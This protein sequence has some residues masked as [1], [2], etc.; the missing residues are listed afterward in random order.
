MY[1]N[2]GV[3][4]HVVFSNFHVP[5]SG[6]LECPGLYYR[7][8]VV[9]QCNAFTVYMCHNNKIITAAKLCVSSHP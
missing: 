5:F 7:M 2:K 6:R 3:A 9:G 1:M 4:L 8:C